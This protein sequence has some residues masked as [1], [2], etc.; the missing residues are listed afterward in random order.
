[1]VSIA[2][3]P[4]VK[5][6]YRERAELVRTFQARTP[7]DEQQL[8]LEELEAD[9]Q[10]ELAEANEWY[11]EVKAKELEWIRDGKNPEIEFN[12]LYAEEP[13]FPEDNAPPFVSRLK[14]QA[15]PLVIGVVALALVVWLG[16]LITRKKRIHTPT[17]A[18][19][20]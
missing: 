19:S 17:A 13:T 15:I 6:S 9:F 3:V 1:M 7:N 5:K 12:A 14:Q 16:F 10:K 4:K 8:P 2:S 20:T 18:S 11:A